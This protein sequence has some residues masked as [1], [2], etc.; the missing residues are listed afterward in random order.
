MNRK[1]Q[2]V[3]RGNIVKI[4]GDEWKI[5]KV[6]DNKVY[7]LHKEFLEERTFD[8]KDNDWKESDLRKYL[9][10]EYYEN[11]VTSIG[12][13]NILPIT[14]DLISLDGQKEYGHSEDYV[15]LLT[16]DLYRENRDILPNTNE[17]WWLAT[18]WS[19]KSN[20]IKTLIC[21]V[22]PLGNVYD[23]SCYGDN[24]VRPFCIFNSSIFESE[25]L[26]ERE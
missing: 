17:W 18:P 5:I 13:E 2:K 8:A 22:S 26:D 25:V 6:E 9:N 23:G 3:S 24:A 20:D 4:A 11:L 10:I 19:T 15:S 12:K 1:T 21:V 7:C 14:T 16:V